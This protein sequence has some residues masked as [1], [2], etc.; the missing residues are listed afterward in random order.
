MI[1]TKKQFESF[2]RAEI[3]PEIRAEYEQDGYMDIPARREA[4]ND[5]ADAMAADRAIPKHGAEWVCPW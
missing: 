3:L 4:W 5:L 2:F 1:R